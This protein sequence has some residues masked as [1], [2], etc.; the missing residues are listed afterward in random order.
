MLSQVLQAAE[1][2]LPPAVMSPSIPLPKAPTPA[3]IAS[4]ATDG[5][6]RSA[7]ARESS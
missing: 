6:S 2:N 1:W 4:R 5:K 7:K 3:V